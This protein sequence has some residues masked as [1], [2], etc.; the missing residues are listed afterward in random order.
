MTLPS[1]EGELIFIKVRRCFAIK[2][3]NNKNTK[4]R[5]IG[6]V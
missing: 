3:K 6:L 5:G 4:V 2:K 1:C